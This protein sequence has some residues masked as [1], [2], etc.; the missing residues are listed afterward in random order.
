[1]W[2]AIA[3]AAIWMALSPITYLLFFIL[4]YKPIYAYVAALDKQNIVG[5]RN[6][7]PIPL[8]IIQLLFLIPLWIGHKAILAFSVGA[9]FYGVFLM[10]QTLIQFGG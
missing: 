10:V 1:M 2:T 7:T 8:R 6:L 9:F 4:C 5:G 3:V